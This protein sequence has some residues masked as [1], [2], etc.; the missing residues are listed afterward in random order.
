MMAWLADVLL[1]IPR[2]IVEGLEDLLGDLTAALLDMLAFLVD[3]LQVLMG[4]FVDGLYWVWDNTQAELYEGLFG[5]LA[6]LDI[7]DLTL[8]IQAAWDAIPWE[9][10]AYFAQ[11]FHIDVGIGSIVAAHAIRFLIRRIPVIG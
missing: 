2:A 3:V 6:S 9:T 4:W 7:P 1:Y 11:P 8:D 5:V 10:A